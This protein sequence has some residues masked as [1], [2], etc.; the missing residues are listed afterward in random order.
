MIVNHQGRKTKVQPNILIF[1]TDQQRA[2]SIPPFGRA[3]TPNLDAFT[4]EAVTFSQA[5]TCSP[6]CCPSRATFFSGL[7]PS[8]HGVWN[9][10][11]VGNALSKGLHDDVKLWSEDLRASGYD[12][13]FSGKWHVS[14]YET[15]AQRG[16]NIP[17]A[18]GTLTGSGG[19]RNSR[20]HTKEWNPYKKGSRT[21]EQAE[22]Q[23]AQILRLGYGTYTHYGVKDNPFGDSTVVDEAVSF[24][25]NRTCPDKPWCQYVGT[26]GPHD[27]YF[28][29]QKYLDMYDI[30][31]IELPA[32]FGD[33]LKDKPN[34]YRRTRD[35]FDQLTPEEH[36]EAIRHYLAFCTY[37]DDLFG[38]LLDALKQ[39]GDYD[40][41]V[42]VYT[43][44]HGDY[45]AEHGLWTKGLP[46]FKPAYHIPAVI[47]L[48]GQSAGRVADELVSI[49]DFGPTFLEAA[50]I[51][52]GR[53]FTGRSL[54]PLLNNE[55]SVSW[56]DAIFTQS[57]GNELY[58]IQRSV[59][60]HE[61][62]YV[63]N[64][65]DYDE[66][67]DLKADPGETRNVIDDPK[68][69]D[70]VK[71]LSKRLWTFAYDTNDVCINNYIMVAHAPYGPGV[72]FSEE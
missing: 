24:I 23:T 40:N 2:D 65:F 38:R 69:K 56:R 16:W 58:G 67:Y 34:L 20:P 50:G 28:L 53:P 71:E 64:G 36:K 19:S 41:T 6:H 25:L 62:K 60:T 22:R 72:I 27:P 66:L 59:M 33:T 43:S 3:K 37:E 11:S 46:C 61:W 32:N 9:N 35:R 13:Y 47:K 55:P 51:D 26:L 7:Y 44:D 5:Y 54:I 49:A 63:Y 8:E 30:A 12:M 14:S 1:M 42:I 31:D 21:T 29:P 70:T 4:K 10:V 48:P 52:A 57:N 39:S 15:P 18:T 45:M 68:H 17:S